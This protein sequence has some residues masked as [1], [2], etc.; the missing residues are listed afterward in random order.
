MILSNL[1]FLYDEEGSGE[2]TKE[3]SIQEE[4][5][6]GQNKQIGD[7]LNAISSTPQMVDRASKNTEEE[8]DE[9]KEEETSEKDEEVEPE[10]EETEE[11]E[12][13]A[14][15]IKARKEKEK[16]KEKT[17]KAKKE[18]KAEEEEEETP[19]IN[20]KLLKMLDAQ[21]AGLS[22]DEGETEISEEEKKEVEE[23]KEKEVTTPAVASVDFV[24]QENF[25]DFLGSPEGLNELGKLI[26]TA[27]EKNALIKVLGALKVLIPQ[28]TEIV[29]NREKF[30]ENNDDLKIVRNLV[31][32]QANKIRAKDPNKPFIEVLEQAAKEVREATGLA[33][34]KISSK[35]QTRE[36]GKKKETKAKFAGSRSGVNN[37]REEKPNPNKDKS[38]LDLQID[39]MLEAV[40]F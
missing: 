3:D 30:F 9:E 38:D 19:E 35:D 26:S 39:E 37:N 36:N 23:K 40:S 21:A 34:A 18:E 15:K 12:S 29:I 5:D 31:G 2:S 7:L 24:N 6:E 11:K 20:E 10:E 4:F 14:D 27:T 25:E 22:L 33:K 32:V 16:E 17:E 8:S 28:Y 13:L 1:R